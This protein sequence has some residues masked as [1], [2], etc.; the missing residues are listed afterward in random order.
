MST[1]EYLRQKIPHAN[2][3]HLKNANCKNLPNPELTKDLTV[4]NS[5]LD[6]KLDNEKSEP[7]NHQVNKVK[8]KRHGISHL[9]ICNAEGYL[10]YLSSRSYSFS[11]PKNFALMNKL[12][13]NLFEQ[14]CLKMQ[15]YGLRTTDDLKKIKN[16]FAKFKIDYQLLDYKSAPLIIDQVNS[17][18]TTQQSAAATVVNNSASQT[19]DH[20]LLDPLLLQTS[21]QFAETTADYIEKLAIEYK[22]SSVVL[23]EYFLFWQKQGISCKDHKQLI[24]ELCT[25]FM[26]SEEFKN[27][28][29]G[30]LRNFA[31]NNQ[32]VFHSLQYYINKLT[33]PHLD[34]KQSKQN[35]K[36]PLTGFQ[37]ILPK[38]PISGNFA[39]QEVV[40]PTNYAV[41]EEVLL[42]DN[43][44]EEEEEVV[45]LL[46]KSAEE[47]AL[48]NNQAETNDFN[49]EELMKVQS[50]LKPLLLSPGFGNEDDDLTLLVFSQQNSQAQERGS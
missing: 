22:I 4:L 15:Q 16:A 49:F 9:A 26:Q 12:E 48:P 30:A 27:G 37:P 38:G 41:V 45:V 18:E 1:E 29:E 10:K 31:D 13:P 14:Y 23:N 47:K 33:K 20:K 2:L 24:K 28:A 11:T 34:A 36:K 43:Y 39:M 35:L 17:N 7:S 50:K 25:Y 46:N 21:H 3:S 19:T 32:V 40:P 5:K 6:A 42:P 44:P 8:A